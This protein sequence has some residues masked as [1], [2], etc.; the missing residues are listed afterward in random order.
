MLFMEK[1]GYS[2]NDSTIF[3]DNKIEIIIETNVR[4]S[5]TRNLRHNNA[6]YFFMTGSIGKGEV[7]VEYCPTHLIFS[8]YLTKKRMGARLSELINMIMG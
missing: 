3:Q 7:K 1:Q 5:F 2:I 4:N 6:W 8:Y